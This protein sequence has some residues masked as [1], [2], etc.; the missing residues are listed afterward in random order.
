MRRAR[1]QLDGSGKYTVV[2][3]DES[4][5]DMEMAAEYGEREHEVEQPSPQPVAM[6]PHYKVW[7]GHNRFCCGGRMMTGPW[8]DWPFNCCAWSSIAIPCFLYFRFAAPVRA[9]AS[10][11]GKWRRAAFRA[12]ISLPLHLPP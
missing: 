4:A 10:P 8:D 2:S 11:P 3:I 6:V 5:V 12:P 1:Q 7:P 9:A